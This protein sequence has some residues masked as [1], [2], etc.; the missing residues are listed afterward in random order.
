MNLEWDEIRALAAYVWS[1]SNGD[2]IPRRGNG[3]RDP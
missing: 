3:D 2:F 1:L